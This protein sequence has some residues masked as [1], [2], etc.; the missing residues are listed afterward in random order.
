MIPSADLPDTLP[1][2]PLPGALLLPRGRLPL[3]IF[4]PRYLKLIDEMDRASPKLAL[5]KSGSRRAG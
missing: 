4:E 5:R 1:L 2:F 3:N